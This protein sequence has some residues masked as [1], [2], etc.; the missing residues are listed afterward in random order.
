MEMLTDMDRL[1]LVAALGQS[2]LTAGEINP[3]SLGLLLKLSAP[4]TRLWIQ[5]A[6]A[7]QGLLPKFGQ[8]FAT[9]K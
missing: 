2:V 1:R 9:A 5:K 7:D 6:V 4:N 3:E 8:N